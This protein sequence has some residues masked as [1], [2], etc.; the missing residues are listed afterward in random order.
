MIAGAETISEI[1]ADKYIQ[2]LEGVETSKGHWSYDV[3]FTDDL[4]KQLNEH[5]YSVVK[6]LNTVD[7]IDSFTEDPIADGKYQLFLQEGVDGEELR[8]NIASAMAE[9]SSAAAEA[10]DEQMPLAA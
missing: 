2:N 10:E 1:G 9:I 4:I 5:R 3:L 8:N 6:F 7:G